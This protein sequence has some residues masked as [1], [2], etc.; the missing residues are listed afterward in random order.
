MRIRHEKKNSG[1]ICIGIG[2]QISS[3]VF[4]CIG[5]EPKSGL[6]RD[7]GTDYNPGMCLLALTVI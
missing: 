2:G 4:I 1:W 6:A 5:D 7:L 3:V